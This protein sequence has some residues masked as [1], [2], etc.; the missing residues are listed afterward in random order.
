MH[1]IATAPSHDSGLEAAIAAATD[2]DDHALSQPLEA[3]SLEDF[4]DLVPG[5]PS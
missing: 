1:N 2:S 3:W 4:Q 5:R